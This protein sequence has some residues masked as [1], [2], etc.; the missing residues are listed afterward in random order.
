LRLDALAHRRR[1]APVQVPQ[2]LLQ[3]ILVE[4]GKLGEE[5]VAVHP[6]CGDDTEATGECDIVAGGQLA[7]EGSIDSTQ[8]GFEA[9]RGAAAS[10]P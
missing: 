6:V 9:G 4:H 3:T 10:S 1:T 5:L 8:R 2:H 7:A